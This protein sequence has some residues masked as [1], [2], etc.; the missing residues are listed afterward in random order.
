MFLNRFYQ[1]HTPLNMHI[2]NLSS[3]YYYLCIICKSQCGL[4]SSMFFATIKTNTSSQSTD[5]SCGQQTDINWT[6][7]GWMYQTIYVA[8]D[9]P[10][11]KSTVDTTMYPNSTDLCS[12]VLRYAQFILASLKIPYSIWHI[13]NYLTHWGIPVPVWIWIQF[14]PESTQMPLMTDGIPRSLSWHRASI[15]L[16]CSSA[17]WHW[18]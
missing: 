12:Y 14:L 8:Q 1:T 16:R 18:R 10:P 17:E 9:Q 3:N 13:D 7:L 15:E 11:L 2:I 6:Q 5:T 4:S